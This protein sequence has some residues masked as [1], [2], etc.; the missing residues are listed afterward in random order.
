MKE[1]IKCNLT[2]QKAKKNTHL[3]AFD[4]R[5]FQSIKKKLKYGDDGGDSHSGVA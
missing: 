2:L 3:K 4:R 5:L 1:K